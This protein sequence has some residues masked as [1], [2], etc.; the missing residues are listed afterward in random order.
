F[1][2]DMTEIGRNARQFARYL[3]D[4][5][6]DGSL[7]KGVTVGKSG[8]L[9]VDMVRDAESYLPSDLRQEKADHRIL[10]VA[11]KL[12]KDR[13]NVPVIFVTKDVN[14]R[15]KADAL[16]VTAVDF[17]PARVAIEEL[18]PGS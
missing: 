17:D 18:Y 11:L 9:I 5:R 1:K 2:K 3:D 4:A 13:P 12:Q 15:V 14:L 6:K 8:T 10:A 16:G 7:T